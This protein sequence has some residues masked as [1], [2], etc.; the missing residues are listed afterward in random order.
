[1]AWTIF[2]GDT[3]EVIMTVADELTAERV[4]ARSPKYV[5]DPTCT[6]GT[7]YWVCDEDHAIEELVACLGSM[8]LTSARSMIGLGEGTT[9][10]SQ[11]LFI[12]VLLRFAQGRFGYI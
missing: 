10:R 11:R 9:F 8:L 2:N 6:H 3:N 5:M 4:A 7:S 12:K 1:M